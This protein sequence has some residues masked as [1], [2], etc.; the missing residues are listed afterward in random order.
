MKRVQCLTALASHRPRVELRGCV[1][2]FG[3]ALLLE[4]ALS[5]LLRAL[6][7]PTV[8][9]LPWCLLTRVESSPSSVRRRF[10]VGGLVPTSHADG[11]ETESSTPPALASTPAKPKGLFRPRRDRRRL[12][13]PPK[14]WLRHA[15]LGSTVRRPPRPRRSSKRRRWLAFLVIIDPQGDLAGWPSALTWANLRETV[16]CTSQTI[17]PLRGP[18]GYRYEAKLPLCI[19]P[20]RAPRRFGP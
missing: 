7:T 12:T 15:M 19:D 10:A 16:C 3:V 6:K 4:C 8:F 1:A 5:A 18:F 11:L 13:S 20:F 17:T 2:C 14:S 9:G